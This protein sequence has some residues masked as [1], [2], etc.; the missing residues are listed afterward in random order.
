MVYSK[1]PVSLADL[2]VLVSV[3]KPV[4]FS[5]RAIV[6]YGMRFM[7]HGCGKV[8]SLT[9]NSCCWVHDIKCLIPKFLVGGV[10][11]VI[12]VTNSTKAHAQ[13]GKLFFGSYLL[14]EPCQ[15]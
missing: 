2:C 3:T 14:I 15:P 9:A 7:V 10:H 13:S 11:A 4:K 5:I 12:D 1:I 6:L 8:F